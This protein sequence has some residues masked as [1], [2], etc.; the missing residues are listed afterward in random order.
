[1]T[2]EDIVKSDSFKENLSKYWKA[3]RED[4]E[5]IRQSYALMVKAGGSPNYK[6]PAHP[7]DKCITMSDDEMLSEF[8]LII[9]KKSEKSM[10]VRQYISQ[11]CQQAYNL[12]VSQI[13]VK[14]YP[15]LE[16]VLIPKSKAS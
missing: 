8:M 10:A 11:L 15:E 9:Q 1:M 2:V 3:Q 12:T 5:A 6:L 4:R 14:E 13:V 7:I 16:E